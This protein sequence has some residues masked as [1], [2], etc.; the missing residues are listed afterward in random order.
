ELGSIRPRG[1]TPAERISSI[2]RA[3]LK[4]VRS[5][6]HLIEL[7]VTQ[8]RGE[9]VFIKAEE[10]LA[11]ELLASGLSGKEAAFAFGTIMFNFGGFVLLEHALSNDYRFRG[12]AHWAST[13]DIDEEMLAALHEHSDLDEIYRITVEA[14]L[15]KLL[16]QGSADPK[17]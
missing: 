16:P 9:A 12:T 15:A 17:R 2:L 3:L 5:R 7:S 8:G 10:V 13:D 14:L 6:P 4:E 11:R 1:S